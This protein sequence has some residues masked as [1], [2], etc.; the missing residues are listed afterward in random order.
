ML[1]S[2]KWADICF[3]AM[4]EY[5]PEDFATVEAIEK[6][7]S[8]TEHIDVIGNYQIS[9][10]GNND[11]VAKY[12]S[13]AGLGHKEVSNYNGALDYY[14]VSESIRKNNGNE[15]ALGVVYN[16]IAVVYNIQTKYKFALEYIRKTIAITKKYDAPQIELIIAYNNMASI[17][18]RCTDYS[19]SLEWNTKA[20]ETAKI[21]DLTTNPVAADIYIMRSAIHYVNKEFH[22]ALKLDF[23]ALDVLRTHYAEDHADIG[24]VYNSIAREHYSLY[25]HDV[26][27]D[28][29]LRAHRIYKKVYG[30]C[31]ADTAGVCGNIAMT[32]IALGDFENALIWCLET[33]QVQEKVLG[34]THPETMLRHSIISEIYESLEL[35]EDAIS[36]LL[37]IFDYYRGIKDDEIVKIVSARLSNNYERT[38]NFSEALRF[39]EMALPLEDESHAKPNHI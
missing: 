26:A 5:I 4:L 20:L 7:R 33:L 24:A 10:D 34:K 6:F 35:Y 1:E 16:N 15:E 30:E 37:T 2:K 8:I 19:S 21:N 22:D 11:D 29:Y 36:H 14:S 27:L 32:H 39:R 12:Y 17:Y 13:K 38:N 9:A 25:Q 23:M 18:L 3:H 28:Y 31:D